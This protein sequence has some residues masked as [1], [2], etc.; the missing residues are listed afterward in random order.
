ML[1]GPD[2]RTY[3]AC[4]TSTNFMHVIHY[5][6]RRGEAAELEKN[7]QVPMR[8]NF[9]FPTTPNLFATC[10]SSIEFGLT[11]SISDTDQSQEA[12]IVYP[13]PTH[14]LVTIKLPTYDIGI[15]TVH[16]VIGE[17]VLLITNSHGEDTFDIDLINLESGI[18]SVTYTTQHQSYKGQVVKH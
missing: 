4:A 10:D 12:M 2:C 3:I 11:S 15:L 5:P 6:D 17:Q 8:L 13:N 16:N 9:A 7:I 18:Y 14:D 1:T